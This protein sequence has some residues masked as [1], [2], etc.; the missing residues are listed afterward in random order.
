MHRD[1]RGT[2][3]YVL[4]SMTAITLALLLWIGTPAHGQGMSSPTNPAQGND[5]K[6]WQIAAMDKFLDS[7]PEIEEQLRKDPS[8]IRN[9][10]FVEKHPALQQY[11][12]EHPGIREEFTENPNAFM[13]QEER[14]ERR[15]DSDVRPR[16][17]DRDITREELANMDRFMDSHPEIAEQLRKDPSLIRNK[18]FVENH[19][20]LQEFL[21]SH[22]L[23][24]I[25]M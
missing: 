5:T 15:E 2:R 23:G 12:Q 9:D 22:A 11:L 8:L 17:G 1:N 20:A 10:E 7:H 4:H 6:G 25:A 18:Q 3:L 19:P 21:Q 24:A 14:Y 13:R 16:S